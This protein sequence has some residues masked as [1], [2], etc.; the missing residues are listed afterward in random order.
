MPPSSISSS[1]QEGFTNSTAYDTHR[2]TYSP[3][4]V[5]F[6][7]EQLRVAGKKHAT[8][9][10]VAAGTGKF[11]EALAARDEEFRIIAVEPHADMRDVLVKKRLRGV[12][13]VEGLGDSMPGIGDESVDA[14]TVAQVSKGWSSPFL[15]SSFPCVCVYYVSFASVKEERRVRK[16][17]RNDRRALLI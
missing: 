12:E 14:V 1:V 10:D 2:P 6:L 13:V 17:A 3:T 5:Q 11:T 8:I 7:L 15:V 16:K 9:V 4:I